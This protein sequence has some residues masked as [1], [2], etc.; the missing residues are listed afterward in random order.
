[1]KL[2]ESEEQ[3][4]EAVTL[5]NGGLHELLA[6]NQ[7]LDWMGKRSEAEQ[8]IRSAL[9]SYPLPV[10]DLL[11]QVPAFLGRSNLVAAVEI[12]REAARR[13][14]NL[15]SARARLV[16]SLIESGRGEEAATELKP[17]VLSDSVRVESQD[18]VAMST[19]GMAFQSV[20]QID[21]ARKWLTLALATSDPVGQAY[22]LYANSI[23]IKA[24]DEPFVKSI[25]K[26]LQSSTAPSDRAAL[27]F[28]LG[29]AYQDLGRFEE[30]MSQFDAAN[31]GRQPGQADQQPPSPDDAHR[32]AWSFTADWIADAAGK[33]SVSEIPILV[34]GM[35]RSGTTLTELVLAS[36]PDVGGAGEVPYWIYNSLDLLSDSGSL[37]L[38]RLGESGQRYAN[39]LG[40]IQPGKRWVVDKMPA[41]YKYL[42]LIHVALPNA[43]F[44]HIRRNPIDT[45]LSIYTTYSSALVGS[46]NPK[47]DLVK[48]YREYRSIV[49]RWRE[50]LPQNRFLDLDYEELV[51]NPEPTIRRLLEFC[52]IEW[53]EACLHPELNARAVAS[54]TL[55]QSRR[56]FNTDSIGRWKNYEPWIGELAELKT[57]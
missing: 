6:L 12:S 35:M 3:L 27:H 29:K 28:A 5:S 30:A 22:N 51:G 24:S 1:M 56:P 18:S 8:V 17:L 25:E 57:V 15:L 53:N 9:R 40:T 45:C 10:E 13:A 47:A 16:W 4:R 21:Q 14:P 43:R 44:I 54:P 52:G 7:C 49:A 31:S 38:D 23:R 33:G 42:G 11:N 19:V 37:R 48:M 46:Q 20:G 50:I 55:W 36:H 41:N 2:I 34:V 32:I 39:L 26:R